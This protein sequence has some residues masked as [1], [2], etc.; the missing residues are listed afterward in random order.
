M[1]L[2]A[3]FDVSFTIKVQNLSK[4]FI[5]S[6]LLKDDLTK[7]F[8]DT[9]NIKVVSVTTSGGLVKNNGYDGISNTDLVT[10]SSSIDI[11]KTDSVILRINVA[12]N[13][14]GNFLN[15]VIAS[16]P[17]T[18]GLLSYVSTDPTKMLLN[19]TARKPTPFL[20]PKVDFKIAEGFSPNND[21]IDDT[22]IILKPFGS[23]VS[24]KVFNRW[25]NEVYKSEDYKNDWR[26]KGV[27]NFLGEDVPEGTYYYIVE[28]INIDGGNIRLAGPLTIKR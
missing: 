16:A 7:V 14:S 23:K 10:I 19:D 25:G 27:S 21:G 17:T 18:Y 11:N 12:N 22:W 6:V 4:E 13:T 26:G 9:R 15:N 5:D 1:N 20:I 2:D 28:G 3:S 8:S 24:V